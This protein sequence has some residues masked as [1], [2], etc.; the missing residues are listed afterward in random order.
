M[1]CGGGLARQ[2]WAG[3]ASATI[4]S[5]DSN[6]QPEPARVTIQEG[7]L[8]D[9]IDGRE[10]RYDIY[11]P[12]GG[13]RN[14][15]GVLLIHGGAWLQGD[16]SQLRGYGIFLGRLGYVCVSA[17]YRLSGEAKWPAQIHDVKAALRWMRA[18]ADTLG[19]DPARIAVHGNSAGAHLAL[20]LAGTPNVPEF[21]GA[22]VHPGVDTS[23]SACVAI[24]APTLLAMRSLSDAIGQLMGPGA[25]AEDYRAASPVT[26]ARKEF[27]P[28]ML[29][30]GMKDEVVP[31]AASAQMHEALEKTGATVD[32][33]LFSGM[34][35]AFDADSAYSRTIA[36]LIDLFLRR[37]VAAGGR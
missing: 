17:A 6:V 14:A 11:T 33:H 5:G 7:V 35:H 34:P 30:H 28:T 21:E 29:V 23:V 9:T 1:A 18:N 3:E 37:N 27:P 26:Y 32:L 15:P 8:I 20:M 12:P 19:V 24:Y 22:G 2:E 16:P 4:E 31:W 10:L 25:S 36:G 13:G